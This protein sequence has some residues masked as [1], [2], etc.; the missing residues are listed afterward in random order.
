MLR[1]AV[2]RRREKQD[3]YFVMVLFEVTPDDGSATFMDQETLFVGS[4]TFA[5]LEPGNVV[6][7]RY[8]GAREHV[9]PSSP[10]TVLT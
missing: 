10:V 5:K 4:P 6:R 1:R 2:V 9:Y 8:D 3:D 7:V